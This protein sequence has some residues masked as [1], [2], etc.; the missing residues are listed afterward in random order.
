MSGNLCT[1]GKRFKYVISCSNTSYD[2][3]NSL[4]SGHLAYDLILRSPTSTLVQVSKL[5]RDD[6]LIEIEATAIVPGKII[7]AK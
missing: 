2:E 1:E 7:P 4:P 3:S 6:I 5:F